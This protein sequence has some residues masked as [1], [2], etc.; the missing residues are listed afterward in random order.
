MISGNITTRISDHLPQLL[1]SPNTFADPRSNKSNVFERGWSNFDQGN[2]VLDYFDTD[3]PY[4]L[5]LNEKN[6]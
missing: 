5:K 4:I 6:C 1:I 3:W 2:F